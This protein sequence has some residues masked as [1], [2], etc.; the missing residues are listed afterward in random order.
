MQLIKLQSLLVKLAASQSPPVVK[1]CICTPAD[2]VGGRKV[3]AALRLVELEGQTQ[4]LCVVILT[5]RTA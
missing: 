1:A 2:A 4:H 5:C 3:A